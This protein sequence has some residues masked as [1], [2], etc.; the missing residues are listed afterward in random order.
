MWGLVRCLRTP[1]SRA[2]CLRLALLALT[3]N[4]NPMYECMQAEAR[5]LI[6]GRTSWH[7]DGVRHAAAARP[8]QAPRCAR[9]RDK[10][11]G[12]A[13]PDFSKASPTPRMPAV[14]SRESSL[15]PRPVGT[16]PECVPPWRHTLSTRTVRP[17]GTCRAPATIAAG[18]FVYEAPMAR[19]PPCIADR[20]RRGLLPF[21]EEQKPSPPPPA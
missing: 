9:V 6:L 16:V 13:M 7:Y 14:L 18:R 17:P 2:S 19:P 11:A 12:R 20:A 15:E 1:S 21:R 5:V 4:D 3:G 10:V 8:P